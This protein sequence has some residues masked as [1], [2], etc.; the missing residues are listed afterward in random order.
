MRSQTMKKQAYNL[1]G[2]A[3][4]KQ[5][6]L[7]LQKQATVIRGPLIGRTNPLSLSRGKLMTRYKYRGG[8][9]VS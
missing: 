2:T 1:Y 4:H 3:V 6:V 8:N 7:P 9:P 5:L